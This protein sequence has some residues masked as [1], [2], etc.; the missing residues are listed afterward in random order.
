MKKALVGLGAIAVIVISVVLYGDFRV[1]AHKKA[2]VSESISSASHIREFVSKNRRLPQ[3]LQEV[4]LAPHYEV[5][6]DLDD[7][8]NRVPLSRDMAIHGNSVVVTYHGIEESGPV[9]MVMQ[10][11]IV[12]PDGVVKMDCTGGTLDRDYRIQA[13]KK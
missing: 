4:G 8:G 5:K 7:T 11:S 12:V 9:T 3:S 13:C 6:W 2:F 1:K 10:F